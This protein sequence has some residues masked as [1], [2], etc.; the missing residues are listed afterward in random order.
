MRRKRRLYLILFLAA[1]VAFWY[2]FSMFPSTTNN[3][4]RDTYTPGVYDDGKGHRLLYRQLAPPRTSR[5]G[6]YPLVV[7][8]HGAGER[9]TDNRGQLRYVARVFLRPD[10]RRQYPCY[11]L[12]PQCP[13]NEYWVHAR[14]IGPRFVPNDTPTWQVRAVLQLIE[15]LK[16]RE[17][18]DPARV[19]LIGF[20]MGGSATWDLL[21]K[22]PKLFAAA[23][24]ICGRGDIA[25]AKTVAPVPL[26][27]FHGARDNQ[28][29]V[30][31][32]RDMVAALRRAGGH[33][34]YTE[35]P[36]GGHN[37]WDRAV[38][39]PELLSWLFQQRLK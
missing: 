33:P 32:S 39:E 13:P 18:I 31:W 34:K 30:S 19:Y 22:H 28:V 25:R 14:Y 36:D 5:G 15:A 11:V 7:I 2:I 35:Y 12:A 29:G 1:L 17:H 24:P 8:L 27:V 20:S 4:S 16:A 37:I 38:A 26:W 9:G 3:H 21:V 6:K 23:V 10:M